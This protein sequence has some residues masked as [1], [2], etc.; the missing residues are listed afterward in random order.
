MS[1]APTALM[2]NISQLAALMVLLA[3]QVSFAQSGGTTA[4]AE[5]SSNAKFSY[6]VTLQTNTPT[7]ID[8]IGP[9]Q[10]DYDAEV[11]APLHAVQATKAAQAATAAQAAAAAKVAARAAAAKAKVTV[12]T[13]SA[14][15]AAASMLALR[16]CEAGGSYTRNSG[17]GYY[18]AYQFDLR[19][20][21]G[22]GGYARADL[23]PA[24]VQDA[25]FLDTFAR[26]GW[27]PWPTCSHKLGLR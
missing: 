21:G 4:L 14:P 16:Q 2:R 12:A 18:G 7:A 22:Y 15:A 27:S 20:W 3:T 17:N 8:V 23:A 11:L 19:T 6:E 10:P 9:K 24:S 13:V 5:D 26:R 25:K 1:R